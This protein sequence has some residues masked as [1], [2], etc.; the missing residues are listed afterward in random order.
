MVKF[1][2]N[3][4]LTRKDLNKIFGTKVSRPDAECFELDA[5][6]VNFAMGS[7]RDIK[8]FWDVLDLNDDYNHTLTPA[9]WNSWFEQH[10]AAGGE[11]DAK[12]W[13][14]VENRHGNVVV[15]WFQRSMLI[16]DW[17]AIGEPNPFTKKLIPFKNGYF[18]AV[19]L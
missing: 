5:F 7:G 11:D 12:C 19:D 9:V 2:G 3:S 10:T 4:R 15:G 13:P 1:A 17:V 6:V 8:G 18:K 16:S 14:V